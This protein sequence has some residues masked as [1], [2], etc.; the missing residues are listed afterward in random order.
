MDFWEPEP[1]VVQSHLNDVVLS[2]KRNSD[3]KERVVHCDRLRP[4]NRKIHDA[5]EAAGWDSWPTTRDTLPQ[6]PRS[7]FE[8]MG[9]LHLIECPAAARR[10]RPPRQRNIE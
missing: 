4:V 2:I 10:G 9:L 8:E 3:Q 1:Y 5:M 7:I 6:E